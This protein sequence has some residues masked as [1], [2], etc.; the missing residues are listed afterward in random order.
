MDTTL[1]AG[2]PIIGTT[3]AT[4]AQAQAWAKTHG[5]AEWFRELAPLYWQLAAAHGG[6]RP[7][8][9]FAQSAKETRYGLFGG[10]IPGPE[11]HNPCGLKT[12][13][14]G[15]NSDPSAHARFADDATGVSAHLDHLALYAGAD[16]YPRS[17]TPDPRHFASIRGTAPTVEALSGKWAPSADYGPS[18][19]RDFLAGLLAT[20]APP[21]PAPDEPTAAELAAVRAGLNELKA[22]VARLAATLDELRARLT[23]AMAG[24]DT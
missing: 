2:L 6:V 23:R 20:T 16:G 24:F 19:V 17:A 1:L 18:I 12:R 9:A 11:W 10:V 8:I 21:E 14:G 7:D 5:A 15:D 13:Q 22:Q 4:V 3:Q